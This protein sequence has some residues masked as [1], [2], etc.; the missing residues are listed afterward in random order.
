MAAT[1]RQ[2][3]YASPELR[4]QF[5]NEV[6]SGAIC[7]GDLDNDGVSE[8]AV[9]DIHGELA[10]FKGVYDTAPWL[11]CSGLGCIACCGAA[12]FLWPGL[13]SL[14]VVTSE[15]WLHI[16]HLNSLP[17]EEADGSAAQEAAAAAIRRRERLAGPTPRHGRGRARSPRE[18]SDFRLHTCRMPLNCCALLAR[19]QGRQR[20][21]LILGSSDGT[22]YSFQLVHSCPPPPVRRRAGDLGLPGLS[23]K[24]AVE[25]NL[26]KKSGVDVPMRCFFTQV[27][28]SPYE[29][30]EK[31]V[32]TP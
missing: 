9:G 10:I 15:G 23:L 17:P 14:A 26:T 7:A 20:G 18:L 31:Q 4:L 13:I 11:R 32:R 5:G 6:L 2:C 25:W 12:D 1:R 8:L 24:L 3:H 19:R 22:V 29:P 30:D 16:F 28:A 21:E 27:T